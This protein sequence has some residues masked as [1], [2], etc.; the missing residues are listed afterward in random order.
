MSQSGVMVWYIPR[1]VSMYDYLH[2]CLSTLAV[3]GI[4]RET[5]KRPETQAT[6]KPI[7]SE[8]LEVFF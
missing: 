6:V 4:T 3:Q 2:Q 7:K 1:R 5:Y 8:F